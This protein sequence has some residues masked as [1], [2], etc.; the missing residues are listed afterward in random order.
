MIGENQLLKQ[1]SARNTHLLSLMIIPSPSIADFVSHPNA[2]S[3][4][5]R[6]IQ[7]IIKFV[8]V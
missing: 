3:V 6:L 7:I 2:L 1:I 4:V 8:R 5:E